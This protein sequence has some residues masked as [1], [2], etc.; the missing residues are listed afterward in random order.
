MSELQRL[1]LVAAIVVAVV[2]FTLA[3]RKRPPRHSRVVDPGDLTPGL[4]L[5]TSAD[6][7]SCHRARRQLGKRELSFTEFSWEQAPERF[8]ELSIDAVPSV[9]LVGPEGRA[10]WWRGGVPRR[11]KMPGRGGAVG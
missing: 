10:R 8:Q 6:C 9:V 4:Y 5:F 2:L 11:L 3:A 7:D 1:G